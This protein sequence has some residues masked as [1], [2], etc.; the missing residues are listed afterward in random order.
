MKLILIFFAQGESKVFVCD[1]PGC[2]KSYSRGDQLR[3]HQMKER[4]EYPEQCNMCDAK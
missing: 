1:T 2:G 3:K 4:G